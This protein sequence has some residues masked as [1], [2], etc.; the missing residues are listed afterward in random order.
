MFEQTHATDTDVGFERVWR[1]RE[2]FHFVGRMEEIKTAQASLRSGERIWTGSNA[3]QTIAQVGGVEDLR[4]I[5]DNKSRQSRGAFFLWWQAAE[6]PRKRG[7]SE[8][9]HATLAEGS[10]R[11]L[12]GSALRPF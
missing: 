8:Q 11:K 1:G 3:D 2:T 9:C 6:L 12:D 5:F 4:K 10:A 7:S